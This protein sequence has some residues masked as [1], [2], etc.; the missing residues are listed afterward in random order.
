MFDYKRRSGQ[1]IGAFAP[2]GYLKDPADKHHLI[3]DTDA[4]EIIQLIY[5]M[6]LEGTSKNGISMYLNEHG[7]PS[8]SAYRRIKGLP[9]APL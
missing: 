3:I 5:K 9:V 1:Y 7:I 2:F 4:A 6:L 8:P